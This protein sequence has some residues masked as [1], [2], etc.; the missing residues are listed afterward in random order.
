MTQLAKFKC[1]SK[2]KFSIQ[3]PERVRKPRLTDARRGDTFLW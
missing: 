2:I 3:R 1:P